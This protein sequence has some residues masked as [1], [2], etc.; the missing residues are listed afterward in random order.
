MRLNKQIIIFMI[1]CLCGFILTDKVFSAD[2]DLVWGQVPPD[3]IPKKFAPGIVSTDD[4][5]YACCFSLDG[6]EF[7]F[8]RMGE[9]QQAIFVCKEN[10]GQLSK[11]EVVSI[12]GQDQ[13]GYFESHITPDGKKLIFQ[14]W[15]P[16]PEGVAG[17]PPDYWYCE[18]SDHG[19]SEPKYFGTPFKPRTNMYCS[20]SNNGTIYS[21]LMMEGTIVKS[22]LVKGNY[23]EFKKLDSPINT[24]F[25]EQYPSIAPDESYLIFNSERPVTG[26]SS[27]LF[28]SFKD[29]DG[30][31][32]EPKMIP[33][34]YEPSNMGVISRDGK[35]LFFT[36]YGDIYWVSTSILDKLK[37][38]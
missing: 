9:S 10:K 32:G 23:E 8:S 27:K 37:S 33:T 35:Y 16:L 36:H 31:W 22:E 1:I 13:I 26:T 11:A 14:S 17:S 5:E 18:K 21:A 25:S 7:Y 29:S 34:G 24:E 38:D 19:W 20:V 12:S 2:K 15:R 30:N 28:I 4:H 3:S 6:K